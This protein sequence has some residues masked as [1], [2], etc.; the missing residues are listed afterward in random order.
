MTETK[1]NYAESET[2]EH[3]LKIC[4]YLARKGSIKR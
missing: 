3:V 2:L 1:A 4:E